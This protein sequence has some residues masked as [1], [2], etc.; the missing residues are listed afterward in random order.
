[1]GE[2]P[3]GC[4]VAV[5]GGT[6]DGKEWLRV[7]TLP[8]SKDAAGE[9]EGWCPVPM[10]VAGGW[11]WW[12][13]VAL[14]GGREISGG[15]TGVAPRLP[16]IDTTSEICIEKWTPLGSTKKEASAKPKHPSSAS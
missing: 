2:W 4:P 16:I 11:R 12:D 14:C 1:V 9:R 7:I 13:G 10:L 3:V 6:V 8:H 15:G 5:S